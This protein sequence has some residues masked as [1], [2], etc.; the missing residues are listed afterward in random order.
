MFLYLFVCCVIVKYRPNTLLYP[1][2]SVLLLCF[3]SRFSL[4]LCCVDLAIAVS[5]DQLWYLPFLFFFSLV[6][7]NSTLYFFLQHSSN[8]SKWRKMK[9]NTHGIVLGK[10]IELSLDNWMK[11]SENGKSWSSTLRICCFIFIVC[12]M[13]V[14]VF[15]MCWVFLRSIPFRASVF[16][17]SAIAIVAYM[18][19]SAFCCTKCEDTIPDSLVIIILLLLLIV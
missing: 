15:V 2:C 6:L 12:G 17:L 14:Y 4:R 19:T 18:S 8:S 1:S 7:Y 5:L 3:S 9:C 11:T 10:L 13:W 16:F